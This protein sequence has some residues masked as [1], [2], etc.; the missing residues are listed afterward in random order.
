MPTTTTITTTDERIE[1][2][3]ST[4]TNRRIDPD[5]GTNAALANPVPAKPQVI[6]DELLSI[7]GVPEIAAKLTP[8]QR[9]TLSREEVASIAIAGVRFEAVLTAGFARQIATAPTVG[10][11]RITYLLHEIGEESRHSRVFLRLIE[12]LEPRAHSPLGKPILRRLLDRGIRNIV[13]RPALLYTLVLAGEEIPDLF[14]KLASDHPDTDDVVRAI[15]R[16]H[17]QEEARHLSFARAVLPEIWRTA[18]WHDRFAVRYI[19]PA[20]IKGMFE[21]MVHPGVYATVGLPTW[22]TWKAANRSPKRI[23][24]RHASTQP[25][26]KA[27][28]DAGVFP[29]ADRA[30]AAWRRLTGQGGATA[31]VPS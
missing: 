14:Q 21:T 6:P 23:E 24:L 26:L 17:R 29:S 15:N 2:L 1:R 4:S 25:V 19:A 22:P 16:Y 3:N 31:P 20:V 9:A 28:V 13:S 12:A 8:E 10:D 27:L 11:P 30:P 18:A 5:D 7:A